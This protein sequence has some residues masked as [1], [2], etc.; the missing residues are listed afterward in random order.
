MSKIYLLST[1]E[2]KINALESLHIADLDNIVCV[3]IDYL[4]SI[5]EIKL[6]NETTSQLPP[7]PIG[8]DGGLQCA[9]KRIELFKQ[10][11]GKLNTTN[12]LI[13][14]FDP[15]Y[16]MIIS[17]E[18][19]IVP[20]TR[21]DVCCVVLELNN[22]VVHGYSPDI[23][24]EENTIICNPTYPQEYVCELG[25]VL[26]YG[27]LKGYAVTIGKIINKHHNSIKHNDWSEHF[28]DV[29]RCKQ[30]MFAYSKINKIDFIKNFIRIVPDHPQPNILFS[31]LT[32]LFA[33]VILKRM[34]FEIML[35]KLFEHIGDLKIDYVV[36][37]DAR[38]FIVGS[39]I[40]EKLNAG[41]VTIRKAGKLG[42]SDCHTVQY[43]KE[44]GKDS[45]EIV[46]TIMKPN[47]NILIVD[48]IIAT[49]GTFLGAKILCDK[50]NPNNVFALA[51]S[52]IIECKNIAKEKLGKFYENTIVC[53]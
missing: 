8:Y 13:K 36:G 37:L 17:I 10:L 1:S 29:N 24:N 25:E 3:G 14:D 33:N 18:N 38:G 12:Q 52:E 40:A 7:Q 9:C 30:I 15:C 50:F 20:E 26:D 21:K 43:G 31:D 27:E 5:G 51:V 39:V 48:D 42:G 6:N 41:F 28:G 32:P 34:V 53:F 44:Y 45:F 19:F 11:V 23:A 49:G 4:L 22:I 35:T 16:D 47:K 46:G 2:I